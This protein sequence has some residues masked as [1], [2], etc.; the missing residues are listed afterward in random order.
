M[1]L[2]INRALF[3]LGIY[4]SDRAFEVQCVGGLGEPLEDSNKWND[5]IRGD[6]TITPALDKFYDYSRETSREESFST[7]SRVESPICPKY[8]E[9]RSNLDVL[10]EQEL[11][12]CT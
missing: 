11:R 6:F 8:V 7:P 4:E 10:H 3:T 1:V 2:G 9:N 12:K 5:S